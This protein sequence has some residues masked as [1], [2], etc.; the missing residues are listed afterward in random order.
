MRGI[1]ITALL[2]LWLSVSGQ[3]FESRCGKCKKKWLERYL[4]RSATGGFMQKDALCNTF[5]F[6]KLVVGESLAQPVDG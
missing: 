5:V 2:V 4:V 1:S 6:K 3:W